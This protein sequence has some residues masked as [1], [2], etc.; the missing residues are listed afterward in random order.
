MQWGEARLCRVAW[1][2]TGRKREFPEQRAL[3]RFTGPSALVKEAVWLQQNYKPQLFWLLLKLSD[4]FI[5]ALS[6]SNSRLIEQFCIITST[7]LNINYIS[8]EK[9]KEATDCCGLIWTFLSGEQWMWRSNC[10]ISVSC[11]IILEAK[12]KILIKNWTKCTSQGVIKLCFFIRTKV[13]L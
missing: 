7:S 11:F 2:T 1:Q 8:A 12:I 9:K 13:C 3:G 4:R 10:F 6:K 5:H